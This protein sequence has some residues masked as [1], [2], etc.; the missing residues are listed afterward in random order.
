MSQDLKPEDHPKLE[1]S[2]GSQAEAPC[3]ATSSPTAAECLLDYPRLWNFDTLPGVYRGAVVNLEVKFKGAPTSARRDECDALG[4]A[5]GSSLRQGIQLLKPN[6]CVNSFNEGSFLQSV[7]AEGAAAKWLLEDADNLSRYQV[8][9]RLEFGY[10]TIPRRKLPKQLLAFRELT[11]ILDED[12]EP[13]N[14]KRYFRGMIL[15]YAQKQDD[16]TSS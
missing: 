2:G 9:V 7:Y 3:L 14:A 15:R 6:P 1:V 8:S 11:G 13:P 5:F 10:T 16:K 4:L 12:N